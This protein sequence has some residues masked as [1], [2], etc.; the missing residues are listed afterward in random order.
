LAIPNRDEL[1]CD[2]QLGGVQPGGDVHR[3]GQSGVPRDGDADGTVTFYDGTTGLQ[4]V[5][6]T[7]GIDT[8]T[9]STLARGKHCITAVYS[10][11]VQFL[12]STSSVL[13][14]TIS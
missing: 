12:A 9:L 8:L 4:T 6:L 5:S 3:D 13:T 14:E 7:N 10:D 1:D 2:D 11:D